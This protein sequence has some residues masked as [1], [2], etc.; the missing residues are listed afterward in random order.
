MANENETVA[1]IRRC[2]EKRF[3][4][5]CGRCAV[6][7]GLLQAMQEFNLVFDRIETAHE[8]ELRQA[9]EHGQAHMEKVAAGNC[10]D[11]VLRG[12]NT[13]RLREAAVRV[14]DFADRIVE[15][16]G[17]ALAIINTCDAALAA[18]PRNCDRFNNAVDAMAELKRR[19]NECADD[20][21]PCRE[22]CPDCGKEKCAMAWLFA[23]AKE[24]GAK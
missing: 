24:G 16:R 11:C 10:R 18:K 1:D 20:N 19:H 2:A 4:E 21:H 7:I 12:G 15:D 3:R 8:R 23:P 5:L 6:G 22:D 13:A 9:M 14:R 17:L